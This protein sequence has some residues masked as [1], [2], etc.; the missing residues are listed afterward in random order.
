MLWVLPLFLLTMPTFLTFFKINCQLGCC[1]KV[2][3]D[4]WSLPF[5]CVKFLDNCD[6]S[7]KG[8]PSQGKFCQVLKN[9]RP[10]VTLLKGN[11]GESGIHSNTIF[12][13]LPHTQKSNQNLI[14]T[15]KQQFARRGIEV[16]KT[17]FYFLLSLSLLWLE[18]ALLFHE[19]STWI[20]N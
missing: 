4:L 2:I 5:Q 9:S 14:L 11:R 1:P 18:K 15:S 20:I 16:H 13:K 6:V 8:C 19:Y 3:H 12:K 17:I 10:Q 7:I